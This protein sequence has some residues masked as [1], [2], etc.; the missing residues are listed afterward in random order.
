M[1]V[2]RSLAWMGSAQGLGI[3][4]QFAVQVVLARFLS[5]HEAGIYAVA[6]AVV[7]VLSLLQALGLQALIVREDE[8]TP[9][10][11][12]TTFTINALISI[13]LAV[14]LVL[15]SFVGTAFLGDPGVGR[16]L[17]ALAVVP[18]FA[19]FS[20]LPMAILEREGRFKQIALIGTA[21]TIAGA[22][23]TI[24]LA[25]FGAKYMSAAYG[26]W[27]NAAV[28]M[29][30]M[31]VIAR[32]HASLRVSFAAWRRIADFALQMLAINGIS[33]V[34]LRLSEVLLPKFL[35][36]SA[37]GLYSRASGLNGLI[38]LNVHILIGRVMLVDFV[39]LHRQGISLRSRY[40]A[41]V[42]VVSV[43]LWPVF[44][45]FAVVA[46]PFILNV[47]GARWLPATVPLVFLSL[48]SMTQV[49]ITMT[50][51][52]FTATGQL[53]QQ[54]RVEFIRAIAA[55]A[56]F[57]GGCMISLEAAAAARFVEALVAVMLYRPYLN[58]M[59]DTRATD[60]W[61]I[62]GRNLLLTLVAIAPAA[63]LMTAYGWRADVPL[64]PLGAAV[65]LGMVLWIGA[66][67]AARHPLLVEAR[68]ILG[69]STTA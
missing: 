45:G 35:G 56:L 1:S 8:L 60:F 6:L 41:T 38:W 16:V 62:Y 14:G 69:R 5:L 37:L 58:R 9:E 49:A 3:V 31:I 19:I 34:T 44:A 26:Q 13:A 48:A 40:I 36:L 54:T 28:V 52:L 42:D 12:A 18:I 51:E 10:I 64:L 32:Q 17:R 11:A 59:T 55:L 61:P 43:L 23:V 33:A 15:I 66:L 68:R 57:I 27:A 46:G 30:V 22:G 47:F 7:G 24:V 65:A 67:V 25:L 63:A 20:F 2:S 39:G 21:G 50:W 29:I 53:R 4:L